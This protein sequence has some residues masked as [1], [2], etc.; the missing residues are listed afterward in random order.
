VFLKRAIVQG[1]KS[2]ADRTEFEFGSGITAV[3]GP[4]GC[5]KSNIL[6]A[7]RWVLGEQSARSLRGDRMLDVIFAGSR[8]RKPAN[9]AEVEL[10]FDNTAGV[11]RSDATEVSVGRVLYRSGESEYKLNGNACRLKDV[12]ELLLDTGVGVDAYSVIEQGRVDSLLQASPVERREIFEEAA[13]ISRYKVR[14]T[15]AQRKLERT[16]TNLQRLE[17]IIE[18]LERR[19]RSVR[20]AAGK[21]RNFQEYDARLRELRS[22]FSMA[23]YHQLREKHGQER[24]AAEELDEAL[25]AERARLAA[26]DATAGELDQEL[27]ALDERIRA[28]DVALTELQTEL[29]ALNE[30]IAQ[31]ERRVEELDATRERRRAQAEACGRRV[32]ELT[33]QL[34]E[35]RSALE[36]LRGDEAALVERTG[37]MQRER[38]AAEQRATAARGE[39]EQERVAA[40]DAV[41]RGSLLQNEAE[42]LSQQARRLSAQSERQAARQGELERE[43]GESTAQVEQLRARCQ[44]LEAEADELSGVARDEEQR[45]GALSDEAGDLDGRIGRDKEERSALLSRLRVLEDMERRFEGVDQGTREVLAWRDDPSL[46]GLVAGLV[47]DLLRIDDPRVGLLEHVLSEF[48]GH[49]AVTDTV[50]ALRT[51]HD[52]GVDQAVRLIGLDRVAG[53]RGGAEYAAVAGFVARALDWV[54]C[55]ERYRPLAEHLLG[56]TI[57]VDTRERAAQLA[58]TAP[59]GTAFVALDGWTVRS[60]GRVTHGVGKAAGGLISRKSEIRQLEHE[61]DE[62][63]TRLVTLTRRRMEVDERISDLQLRRQGTLEKLAGVQREHADA[64]SSLARGQDEHMRPSTS[65]R[66]I[67]GRSKSAARARHRGFATS[68]TSIWRK[69][70]PPT[71]TANRT[72]RPS[73]PR[74]RRRCVANSP[75]WATSTWMRLPNWKSLTPRYEHL[76]EQ[77][78]DLEAPSNASRRL[79]A[80]LDEESRTRFAATFNEVRGTSRRCFANFLGAE[81]PISFWKIR[82]IRWNV[83]SRSSRVRPAKSRNPSPCCPVARRR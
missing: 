17:D 61:R 71:S 66:S 5:G 14:R 25:Q 51:L 27:Q 50:A 57:V 21:A 65:A 81:K 73:R 60:D 31:G 12:R 19:L 7:V 26:Q 80:D 79:I 83:A 36:A 43:L 10:I 4:N 76:V 67:C 35:Q 32:A 38:E 23:E 53:G 1:F 74:S 82:R 62:V 59:A 55:A 34:A 42:N 75:V 9:F 29:S 33:A 3:V 58:R 11:L 68:S 70:T 54:V 47:A 69:N 20:L 49:V 78:T 13:G 77:R 39:L 30:R 6:D 15:E 52:R 64:R 48:E 72:G 37:G 16:Q 18:E 41:R 46:A 22:S 56:R 28:A 2:F 44:M 40:F 8:S 63:E 24:T 45:L